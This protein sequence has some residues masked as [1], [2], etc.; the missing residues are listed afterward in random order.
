MKIYNKLV[1]NIF[2]IIDFQCYF[3]SN[4][5]EESLLTVIT[6]SFRTVTDMATWNA[7]VDAEREILMKKVKF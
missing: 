7:E 4:K 2:L 5:I 1:N 6:V 3:R